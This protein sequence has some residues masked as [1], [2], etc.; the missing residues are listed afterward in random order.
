MSSSKVRK[1]I[2]EVE[3]YLSDNAERGPQPD[4][5]ATAVIEHGLRC[6]IEAPD[7]SAIYTDMPASVGGSDTA[8]SPG[9]HMRAALASCDAT[10]LA[11]RAARLGLELDSIQVRVE[12]SSDGRGM[13]LDEGVSPGSER[14]QLYFRI[15]AGNASTEQIESLVE[16]VEQHSPV[17]SDITRAV[18]LCSELETV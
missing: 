4:T 2:E 6:R 16:W 15:G 9:W 14:M 1:A 8:S 18:E 10:L 13:F 17:A 3:Q 11:M 7:G 12:A 5:A